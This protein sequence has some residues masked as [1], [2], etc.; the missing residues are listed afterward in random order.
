VNTLAPACA[1]GTFTVA[2]AVELATVDRSGFIE[3]RHAGSAIVIAHDGSVV[4][5]LGNP[6]API[7]PRSCL[8]PFQTVALLSSGVE[9]RGADAA[10]ATASHAG[11]PAHIA[12]VRGLLNRGKLDED[13]LKCPPDWPADQDSRNALIR[14]GY[15][16]SPVFMCCSGKHA[17]MLL[18]CQAN[19]WPLDT[20][21][22]SHHPLHVR[23]REVVENFTEESVQ[24]TGIDGCGTPVYS[25]SL[26]ALARGIGRISSAPSRI[27]SLIKTHARDLDAHAAHL[28][29][30][31]LA[32][33]WAL[34]GPGR[35]NTAVIEQL[36]IVAKFGAEGLIVLST[37]EGASVAVKVL[38]GDGRAA[39]LIGLQLLV[40]TDILKQAD[41][42]PVLPSL[43]LAVFGG[44]VPVGAIRVSSAV[45]AD[46]HRSTT[47]S[48]KST[49]PSENRACCTHNHDS[50]NRSSP[51][52]QGTT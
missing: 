3:S 31:I 36:G 29:A 16:E 18:A 11:T 4:R 44:G 2:E 40:S 23:V 45:G 48:P 42:D 26:T 21:L 22:D 35:A 5:Q 32:N 25:M 7:F 28:V 51:N 38:D 6:D 34:D 30:A 19:D 47:H 17:A 46:C 10:I 27:G 13:A 8:K 14:A 41:V 33:G 37:Q 24:L 1:P 49:T 43:G 20:Y 15:S 39:T 52:T 9:L 12:L 50:Q